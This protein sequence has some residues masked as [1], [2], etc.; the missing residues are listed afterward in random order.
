MP[1][2]ERVG[3]ANGSAQPGRLQP[4]PESAARGVPPTRPSSGASFIVDN[5]SGDH[6]VVRYLREWCDLAR[7]FDIA[8]GYFEIGALLALDGQWQKLERMRTLMGD[9]VS[10]RTKQAFDAALAR[11]AEALDQS[12]ERQKEADDFLQGVPAIVR[13]LESGQIACRVYRERKFHAKAYITHAKF[14]VLGATALVGSSNYTHPGLHENVELNVQ[15][16]AGVEDLQEWFERHWD[17]AEDVTPSV[18]QVIQRHVREYSPFEVYAK[19]LYEFF[20]GHEVTAGEWERTQSRVYPVLDTY[21]HEGYHALMRIASRYN[22]ALLCDGVGLGKTFIGLMLIERLLFERKNVAL[23]VPKAARKPVW[24]SALERYLPGRVNARFGNNL[25]IY[26]HTDLLRGGDFQRLM[27][28]V[29]READVV[30]VDEAHHFRNQASKR[31]RRF[32]DLLQGKQLFLITATPVN[33]SLLD[34]QHMIELFSRR[35]PDYFKAAPLGIHSL[36]GH[37]RILENALEKVAGTA[38]LD[39]ELTMAEAEQVLA[40]DD[41]ARALVVQRS[42]AYVRRSQ[43][44]SGGAQVLFPRREPPQVAGYSLQKTYGALL[45]DLKRAFFRPGKP[46]LSLAIYYPLNYA[47]EAVAVIDDF[48]RGRQQ[49]VVGLIRTQLLKRFESSARA[50]EATCERLFLK[51][52]AFVVA[53]AES[54]AE[55]RRLARF[56]AQHHE[57]LQRITAHQRPSEEDYEDEDDVLPSEFMEAA[58]VL[59]RSEYR[60]DEILDE[61]YL[62]LDQLAVFLGDLKDLQPAQDDKVQVLINLLQT[63]SRLKAQ[64]VLIFSEY[65]ETAHYVYEQLRR[66]GIGPLDEVHSGVERDRGQIINAF[67]PYYNGSSSADLGGQSIPETRVLVSTDVLSEGLNLQDATL[68]INY[69]LHWNPVRLMQRIGR[70]DRRLDNQ[71]EARLV[72]DHPELKAARGLVRYWNFLPPEELN[73]LLSLYAT[74]AHKTLRISKMFGIEG[75]KLLTPEDDYD[76]LK[77][78][79][80]AYEGTT[81]PAEEM[82]LAYQALLK[83]HP[84]L[85]QSLASFPLRVFSGREHPSPGTR[86][87]F[88]CYTL[89]AHD[90][91]TGKWDEQAGFTRWY[92]Y[93]L[94]TQS[95]LEDAEQINCLIRCDP[96]TPRR[97]VLPAET[98]AEIRLKVERH[99]ANSYLRSVQAPVG[100]KPVSRAWMELN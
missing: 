85:E 81:S 46:L 84:G 61:T 50:F 92:L 27:D 71:T 75:K 89:P 37:F 64:K 25:V 95:I 48:T 29:Q 74:V 70:V 97:Q 45:E 98:L 73:E 24:E 72:A 80:Q 11:I 5:S 21:Q 43:Q 22:G 47:T 56:Q 94:Q 51:L 30:I 79:N 67:S 12:I 16:R 91:A 63:D 44:Q 53:N 33:N 17:A 87:V 40:K 23:F 3:A 82:R 54:P 35:Q 31:Y 59:S 28:E 76:A 1:K 57:L 66:A 90:M 2:S 65:L 18:L 15:L 19:A 60:V 8:T 36:P 69:D 96:D 88:L 42:R 62:D 26:N 7:S 52:F 78:F 41:L 100:V 34:L 77:E 49:Q 9:E 93:D 99:I 39:T 13:A 10:K 6:Q 68:L 4:D 86:A 83:A 32:F 20:R 58:Q 14:D 38:G 55:K